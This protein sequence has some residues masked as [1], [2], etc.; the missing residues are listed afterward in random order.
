MR[1]KEWVDE[2]KVFM[3]KAIGV[4]NISL[5]ILKPV[6]GEKNTCCTETYILIGP[7]NTKK[8]VKN[9]I[10]YIDTKFFHFLVGLL[11]NTQDATSKVYKFVPVQDFSQSWND[12]KLYKKY[13]LTKK[14]IDFIK[15]MVRPME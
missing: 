14:E 8:E 15:S 6:F 12:E 11:K 10:S 5:D 3:P 7:F 4:G 2:Y 13:G 1:N 9:V